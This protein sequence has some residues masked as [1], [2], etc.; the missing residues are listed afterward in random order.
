MGIRRR[1]LPAT[2]VNVTVDPAPAPA[3]HLVEQICNFVADYVLK[4][5]DDLVELEREDVYVLTFNRGL[6]TWVA[7]VNTTVDDN[8]LY[9]VIHNDQDRVILNVF[10]K[11]DGIT[12][13]AAELGL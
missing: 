10:E 13:P 1:N 4:H 2:M 11:V 8:R 5:Y 6:E 7:W 12:R 3:P 9:Q